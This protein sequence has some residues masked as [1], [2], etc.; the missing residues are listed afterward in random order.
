MRYLG[1]KSRYGEDIA[2]VVRSKCTLGQTI[3]EPFCGAGWITQYFPLNYCVMSS[4]IHEPLIMLHRA[5]Q[6]GS[7]EPPDFVSEEEY[8]ELH[9]QWKDGRRDHEVGFVGFACSWG[10]K[11]FAGYSRGGGRNFCLEAKE[12]LLKKHKNLKHV[13]FSHTNYRNIHPQGEVIYCDPPYRGTENYSSGIFD[14]QMFWQVVRKWSKENTV[15]VSE[16]EAPNDF[17]TIWEAEHYSMQGVDSKITTE[18][19]FTVK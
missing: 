10:G 15:I 1:G 14:T 7:W 17:D 8:N 5:L 11:W 18:R 2:R 9:Q 13:T 12:S 4:D 3:R 6:E 19:L 16:Y